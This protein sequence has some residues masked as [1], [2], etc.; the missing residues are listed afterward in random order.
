MPAAFAV[1]QAPLLDLSC[2]CQTDDGRIESE[3]TSS[4]TKEHPMG[5]NALKN[6]TVGR[7]DAV[8]YKAVSS[9]VIRLLREAYPLARVAEVPSYSAKSSFGDLDLLISTEQLQAA[10]GGESL[11]RLAIDKMHCTDLNKNGSVLSVDYRAHDAQTEPGFQVDFIGTPDV[12]FDYSLSYLSYNDLGNLCGKLFHKAGLQHGHD[13][14]WLPIRDG[15]YMAAR[16]LVTRDFDRAL[17]FIGYDPVRFKQGF[18]TLEDIFAFAASSKNFNPDMFLGEHNYKA[19]ER[20]AKRKTYGAFI[21]WLETGPDVPAFEHARDKL[22]WLPRIVEWFPHVEAEYDRALANI[23]EQKKLATRFNGSVVSGLTG[24]QGKQLGAVMTH[25]KS[26]FESTSAFRA[27][28]A[29]VSDEELADRVR[30]VQA[31]L[32]PASCPTPAGFDLS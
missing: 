20:E 1:N 21:T 25:V 27:Y 30:T 17:E 13:G 16:I 31:S 19:R 8:E 15:D 26:A 4:R 23:A 5:G 29:S 22:T 9:A 12:E 32:F 18:D 24:L 6:T 11:R 10:G 7:L 3:Y 28:V 14:L 2:W